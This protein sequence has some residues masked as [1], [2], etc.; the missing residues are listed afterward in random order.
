MEP[1]IILPTTSSQVIICDENVVQSD[2]NRKRL[3]AAKQHDAASEK[4]VKTNLAYR[5]TIQRNLDITKGQGTGKV[6]PFLAERGL[7]PRKESL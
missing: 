5:D 4:V 2:I 1:L 7:R 6:F 3:C